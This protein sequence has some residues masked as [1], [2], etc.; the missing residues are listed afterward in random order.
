MLTAN[1]LRA[2]TGMLLYVW[3]GVGAM[4]FKAKQNNYDENISV[5][6]YNYTTIG[7]SSVFNVKTELDFLRDWT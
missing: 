4:G 7:T 6:P 2:K 5:L 3:G 1:R